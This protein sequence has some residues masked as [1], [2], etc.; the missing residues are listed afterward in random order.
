MIRSIFSRRL[1]LVALGAVLA[2]PGLVHANDEGLQ[3]LHM[4]VLKSSAMV[5]TPTSSG[6]AFVIDVKE[7][8]LL[9]HYQVVR[10]QEQVSVVFPWYQ[11]GKLITETKFYIEKGEPT[12]AKVLAT[13]RRLGLAL[14]QVEKIPDSLVPIVLASEEPAEGD[15]LY[16]VAFDFPKNNPFTMTEHKVT[17]VSQPGVFLQGL[18]MIAGRTISLDVPF[19][20]GNGGAPVVNDA[21]ELVGVSIGGVNPETIGLAVHG[22]DAKKW[23]IDWAR[24]LQPAPVKEEA[25]EPATEEAPMAEAAEVPAADQP[26]TK[27]PAAE[28]V[29][30]EAPANEVEMDSIKK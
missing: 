9:T 11:D 19:Q 10:G 16:A 5:L 8:L 23:V 17:K 2:L 24:S 15:S 4:S 27:E 3:S 28:E 26:A 18:G 14:L 13:N 20:A 6:S 1:V 7:K 25:V 22:G 30:S 12:K 21:G 29:G